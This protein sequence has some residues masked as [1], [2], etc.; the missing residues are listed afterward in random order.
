MDIVTI[1]VLLC[2]H[3][4]CQ[5]RILVSLVPGQLDSYKEGILLMKPCYNRPRIILRAVIYKHHPAFCRILPA[6]ISRT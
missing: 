1:R 2:R 3:Q 4:S 5:Q 6:S